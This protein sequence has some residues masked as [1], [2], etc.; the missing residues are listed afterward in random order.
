MSQTNK[1]QRD[2]WKLLDKLKEKPKKVSYVSHKTLTNHFKSLLNPKEALSKPSRCNEKGPLDYEITLE[3]LELATNSLQP[4]KAVG[5]DNLIN[6]MILCLAQVN[7]LVTL[8][9]FNLILK[10]GELPTEWV[11]SLIVPIHKGGNKTDPS[12]YRGISLASCLGKLFLSILNVRLTDF[13]MK[14]GLLLKTQ[15]GYIKATVPQMHI[16]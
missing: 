13:S 1:S 15:L 14:N 12:N 2:F 6:E 11:I 10:T 8:T 3:E 5:I 16:S 4:G 9:L 7:S